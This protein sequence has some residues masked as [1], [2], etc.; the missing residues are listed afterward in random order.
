MKLWQ[1]IGGGI[2]L[3]GIGV[4]LYFVEVKSATQVSE[5]AS[6]N[7]LAVEIRYKLNKGTGYFQDISDN[8]VMLVQ[9]Q[10]IYLL[11][12]VKVDGQDFSLNKLPSISVVDI[13][14]PYITIRA[15]TESAAGELAKLAGFTL[16]TEEE[17][18]YLIFN[19]KC[20][21]ENFE[22]FQ[23]QYKPNQPQNPS[24]DN[25]KN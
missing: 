11:N 17:N 10:D 13:L 4:G 7:E 18:S 14:H 2:I 24:N 23:K 22:T 12:S 15:F 8:S 3:A 19:G 9:Y 5:N 1:L 25:D 20:S 21:K 6:S 16:V